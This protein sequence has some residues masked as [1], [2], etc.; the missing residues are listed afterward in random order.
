MVILIRTILFVFIFTSCASFDQFN[1]LSSSRILTGGGQTCVFT[2]NKLWCWGWNHYGTLGDGTTI[3]KNPREIEP[4]KFNSLEQVAMGL[5]HICALS[6]KQ[7]YCWGRNLYSQVGHKGTKPFLVKKPKKVEN[8]NEI[9][10]ITGK[11]SHSCAL[12]INM[13]IFCWGKNFYN[14]SGEQIAGNLNAD[15]PQKISGLPKDEVLKIEAHYQHSCALLKNNGLWCWGWNIAGQVGDSDS[16]QNKPNK[17]KLPEGKIKDFA[18]GA[19][20]TCSIVN[21]KLYC[22]GR[23]DLGQLGLED[24]ADKNTVRNVKIDE[25]VVQV[26]AGYKHTCVLTEGKKILC[27]GWNLAGQL[28]RSTKQEFDSSFARADISLSDFDQFSSGYVHNCLKSP[29]NEYICWGG[30]RMGQIDSGIDSTVIK[31]IVVQL[32]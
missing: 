4:I 29:Q 20:H 5:E 25:P 22:W 30:N 27:A 23:N 15:V 10:Q 9:I 13:E 17:V 24:L 31:P 21:T 8:L 26:T 14:Q 3:N 2:K 7:V 12:N 32:K 6:D 1:D 19:F 11:G 28:G 16:L 18:L